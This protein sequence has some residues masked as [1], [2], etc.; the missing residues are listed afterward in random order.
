MKKMKKTL[1]RSLLISVLA[2]SSSVFAQDTYEYHHKVE[3]LKK[4]APPPS[5]LLVMQRNY[6]NLGTVY[7]GQYKEFADF[8]LD[9]PYKLELGGASFA[10]ATF[11]SDGVLSISHSTGNWGSDTFNGLAFSF[12][13]NV[14]LSISKISAPA[15]VVVNVDVLP[16]GEQAFSL[17]Y[18]GMSIS[19]TTYR[20]SYSFQ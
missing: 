8:K 7:A 1:Y 4:A 16:S 11:G 18:A 3:G 13:G 5:G 10:E 9:I 15:G 17:N 12:D 19:A 2:L 14:P 20:Y 6:P